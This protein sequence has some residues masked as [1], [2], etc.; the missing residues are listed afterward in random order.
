VDLIALARKLVDIPS[1]TGE[2]E[3][4]GRF[5]ASYLESLGYSI[6]LQEV[7]ANRF[8]VIA[9]TG[10]APRVVLSTHMDTVPPFIPAN[11]DDERI[12]GRGACDAKGIIAAQIAAAERLRKEGVNEIGLL[13]TVDEEMG[14]IGAR[15]ANEHSIA[16]RVRFLINGE[17][18]DN[19]LAKGTKGSLRLT[20][21][22]EGRAAHSAY[23]ENGDS[24]IET[25]LD[26]LSSIRKCQWPSD[27]FFGETT[28]NI[29]VISGGQRPNVVPAEAHADLQI[30][31]VTEAAPVKSIL[32]RA[33]AG[34]AQVEY[35]SEH[36]PVRLWATEGFEQRVMRFTT[37]IPFLSNWGQ[38]FLLGPGS[39]LNAHTDHEYVT[40]RELDEAVELYTRLVQSL[41][42]RESKQKAG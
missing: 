25:L 29:G 34:R 1:L 16:S 8:N 3:K 33:I 37:D 15:V 39:I 24:A 6:E 4:V 26:V 2:E 35:R 20:I 10:A 40:K 7:G 18:T 17:P 11:E 27:D 13:F 31:L 14:G 23:P 32:E 41:L 19:K 38:P 21:N 30:R 9:T 36:S 5:I 12:Y 42:V 28:C 22:T